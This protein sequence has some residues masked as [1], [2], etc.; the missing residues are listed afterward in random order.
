MYQIHKMTQ[1]NKNFELFK[2]L[3]L[4]EVH[5]IV[6]IISAWPRFYYLGQ[7]ACFH[8]PVEK[9]LID[10]FFFN[11]TIC[12]FDF[13]P[14]WHRIKKFVICEREVKWPN[15]NWNLYCKSVLGSATRWL[16]KKWVSQFYRNIVDLLLLLI[17]V[18]F[19]WMT[20]IY[21]RR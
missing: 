17:F 5:K 2:V 10:M 18:A 20:Q 19:L 4:S 15:L 16:H 13:A 11:V 8:S 7:W 3:T 12:I 1:S 21:L 9:T 6:I 14:R